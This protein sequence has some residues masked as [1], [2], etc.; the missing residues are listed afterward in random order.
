MTVVAT[1]PDQSDSDSE[2]EDDNQVEDG[3]SASATE[4]LQLDFQVDA[5]L[6]LK[7][8]VLLD[9]ISDRESA[10]TASVV[11][12]PAADEGSSDD[13]AGVWDW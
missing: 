1:L 7:S 11:L 10:P 5:E 12:P 4:E 2:N 6:S 8:I 9:M 13:D 3:P